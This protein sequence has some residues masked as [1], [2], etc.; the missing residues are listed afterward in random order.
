MPTRLYK[1]LLKYKKDALNFSYI[2][3]SLFTLDAEAKIQFFSK[4]VNY[5]G[6]RHGRAKN[7]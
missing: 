4:I 7:R 3:K 5:D 6:V 1:N 2:H